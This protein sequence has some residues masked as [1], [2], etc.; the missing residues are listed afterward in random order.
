MTAK[1]FVWSSVTLGIR[2]SRG[3]PVCCHRCGI[4]FVIGDRVRNC[5]SGGRWG[6]SRVYH[7]ACYE[8]ML[9]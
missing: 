6:K 1:V 3:L 9:V 8:G 4:E 7:E 2:V 5:R